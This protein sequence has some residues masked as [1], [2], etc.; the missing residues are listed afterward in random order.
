MVLPLA[1]SGDEWIALG[2]VSSGAIVGLGGL[3]FAFFSGRSER[4]HGER[5]ALSGRLHEQRLTAYVQIAGFLERQ[6][7]FLIR[8]EPF[9]SEPGQADPPPPLNDDEW[10]AVNGLAAVSPSPEVLAALEY[11]QEGARFFEYAVRELRNALDAEGPQLFT[12]R[13]QKD[14]ARQRA[15]A[16]I[17][18]TERVMREELAGL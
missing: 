4:A 6:R 17:N 14:N 8:T 12:A 3:V 16:A 10:A 13:Q 15:I 5:L 1:L 2:G 9:Y 18:E 7:L 11:A